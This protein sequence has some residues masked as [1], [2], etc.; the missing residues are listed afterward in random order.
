ML[1]LIHD[2]TS[3]VLTLFYHLEKLKVGMIGVD[4]IS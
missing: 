2:Y 4:T 1:L 3:V